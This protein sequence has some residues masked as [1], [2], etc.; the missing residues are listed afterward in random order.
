MAGRARGQFVW[1][2][3][4]R[5]DPLLPLA[6]EPFWV[7][8]EVPGRCDKAPT[9][10]KSAHMP[11]WQLAHECPENAFLRAHECQIG[12][13]QFI[14]G[15]FPQTARAWTVACVLRGGARPPHRCTSAAPFPGLALCKPPIN[16]PPAPGPA[17]ASPRPQPSQRLRSLTW[18]PTCTPC[19]VSGGS[20]TAPPPPGQGARLLL[21]KLRPRGAAL[22]ARA[23]ATH[24]LLPP[25]L[26]LRCPPTMLS[27]FTRGLCPSWRAHP[28]HPAAAATP[29]S[30][31]SLPPPFRPVRLP[32]A[33]FLQV[34]GAGD[35]GHV[36]A[37]AHRVCVSRALARALLARVVRL[38]ELTSEGLR[39]CFRELTSEGWLTC[40]REL[41]GFALVSPA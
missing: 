27:S 40:L 35:A 10:P 20:G 29:P 14:R 3:A 32:G 18:T 5:G 8:C 7:A 24:H 38:H 22:H 21:Q 6:P 1:K 4:Y 2:R 23:L 12:P 36:R 31:P 26:R 15:Q 39:P 17:L 9:S 30:P 33:R 16:R 37:P 19:C 13:E 25:P 11:R 34:A 41:R 28:A